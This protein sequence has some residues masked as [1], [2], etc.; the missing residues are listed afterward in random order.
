MLLLQTWL[1]QVT[2]GDKV[3]DDYEEFLLCDKSGNPYYHK[4]SD[5]MPPNLLLRASPGL[6]IK[7]ASRKSTAAA[8]AGH[9]ADTREFVYKPD[10]SSY[11][12]DVNSCE[13]CVC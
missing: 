5:P 3:F 13:V 7:S 6:L 9:Q 10:S 4:A 12:L 8:K 1:P 2:K 11:L